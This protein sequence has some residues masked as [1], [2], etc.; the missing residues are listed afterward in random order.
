VS[1][2]PLDRLAASLRDRLL[3][4]ADA[5]ADGAAATAPADRIADLVEREG[6]LLDGATRAELLRRVTDRA[7]GL[8]PLQPLLEDPRVDEIMV[9]GLRPV[10]VERDGRLDATE[11]AFATDEQLRDVIERILAPLGR[12]LD[13]ASPLV[14]ARA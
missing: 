7:L 12:R 1:A 10:W 9:S 13:E 8:G 14:E 6:A 11:V 5:D 3:A 2:D 4:D